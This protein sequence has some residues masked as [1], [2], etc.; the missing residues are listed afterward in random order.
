MKNTISGKESFMPD[1]DPSRIKVLEKIAALEKAG[2]FDKDVEEDPPTIPIKPGT[3]DYMQKKL[4]TR[5]KAKYTFHLARKFLNKAIKSGQL[6]IKGVYGAENLDAV[7]SGAVLTCN[8]FSA[9]DSFLTQVAYEKSYQ[10]KKRKLFR[11][12]REGNYTNFPGFYGQLMR[13]C[14]TL[15]LSSNPQVMKEFLKG[16]QYLLKQGHYVLIY[17]EQSMWWNYR[18]PK[19]VKGGAYTIASNAKVPVVPIF[20]GMEDTDKIGDDGFPVQAYTIFVGKA[21][22]PKM[23]ASASVNKEHMASENYAQWK[24]M[25]EDFYHI[26]LH[27]TCED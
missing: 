8:H 14:N 12:I 9:M 24:K 5:I 18:K 26:P 11:V 2:I 20:I 27:Y 16:T 3:V 1:K 7:D 10:H 21:I 19:P 13:N 4:S 6:I 17:P 15:P 22:Y 25:Y 23:D